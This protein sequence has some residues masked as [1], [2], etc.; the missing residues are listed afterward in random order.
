[1]QAKNDTNEL[2]FILLFLQSAT[3]GGSQSSLTSHPSLIDVGNPAGSSGSVADFADFQAAGN[4][5]NPRTN[6]GWTLVYSNSCIVD[7][8][9]S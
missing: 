1:M 6:E 8:C 7:L 5:F 3:S 4:D 9:S 2:T